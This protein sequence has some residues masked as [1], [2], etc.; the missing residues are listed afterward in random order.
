MS[1]RA[2]QNP[3]RAEILEDV[4]ELFRKAAERCRQ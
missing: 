1:P 4:A 3:H 2:S